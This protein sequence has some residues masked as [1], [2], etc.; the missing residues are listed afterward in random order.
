MNLSD[1]QNLL[2]N[3]STQHLVA[4]S[5]SV[6]GSSGCHNINR[7]VNKGCNL[8]NSYSLLINIDATVVGCKG[9][10]VMITSNALDQ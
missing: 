6:E 5:C 9:D 8:L 1:L 7:S 10:E 3:L 2:S 4:N